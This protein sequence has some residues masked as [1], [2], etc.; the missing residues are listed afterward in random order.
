MKGLRQGLSPSDRGCSKIFVSLCEICPGP[1]DAPFRRGLAWYVYWLSQ[2]RK[3]TKKNRRD[4][5]FAGMTKL[6]L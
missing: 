4:S 3:G 2:G 6:G 5:A 1:C